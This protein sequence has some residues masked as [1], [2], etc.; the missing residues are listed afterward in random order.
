M[1]SRIAENRPY[2]FL[3][4]E[5]MGIV[6]NGVEDTTSSEARKWTPAYENYTLKEVD[7]ETTEVIIEMDTQEGM[8]EEFS[9]MWPEALKKL[10]K[11]AKRS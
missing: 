10:K 5:H 8:V 2:K 3:S 7:D 6:Q 4:I 11:G 1:V 9:R